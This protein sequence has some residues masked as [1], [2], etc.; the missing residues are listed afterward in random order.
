MTSP[1]GRSSTPAAHRRGA[2]EPAPAQAVGGRVELDAAHQAPAANVAHH[3]G[4]FAGELLEQRTELG[5][6]L[7][8]VGEHV[9]LVEQL[10][11]AERHRGGEG[12]PAV[13]VPV[14]ERALAQVG[15]EE[16][17]VDPTAGDGR[18]HGEVAAGEAL[19]DGHEVGAHAALLGGEERAGAA[20]AG[21]DLVADEQH[22]VLAAGVGRRARRDWGSATRMPAAPCTSGSMT[23]AASSSAWAAISAQAVSAQPSGRRSRARAARGSA[24]G[25]TRRCRSRRRRPRAA[26]RVAV[27]RAA[28]REVAGA[29]GDAL[30][31]PVLEGDLERL[32]DG[33]GAV[34]GEQEV[35]LVD[36]HPRRQRLGQLDDGPVAVAEQGRVGDPVEL[37]AGGL[38]ELG[39]PVAE[40]GDPQR[41][42]G[43]EVAAAVDV[44][45][46]VAVGRLDDHRLV[47]GVARHLGE[48]VP[49]DGGVAVD[50]TL[51]GAGEVGPGRGR[52]LVAGRHP[53]SFAPVA[54]DRRRRRH[55]SMR[56]A[57]G[58]EGGPS[59]KGHSSSAM[60]RQ[61]PVASSSPKMA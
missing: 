40:G 5:G 11:V 33:G 49:H 19:A 25:R 50:P 14:V 15:A 2:H 30:V 59:T 32:L 4:S 23:T 24:A 47:L 38:V 21:G 7:A 8:H 46:L 28:E 44:D 22:V 6:P 42:D 10:E 36:R 35:R 17:V 43:V 57:I 37:L 56:R 16:G 34:G 41:R 53:H 13:G 58:V 55:S 39:H 26:D 45:E 18:R 54:S 52:G 31:G 48:A 12:V 9:P 61:F 29:A 51:M 60:R 3:G 20:E 1:S 27:V